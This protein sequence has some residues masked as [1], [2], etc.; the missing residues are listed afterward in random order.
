MLIKKWLNLLL[1]SSTFNSYNM[2]NIVLVSEHG[3]PSI[4]YLMKYLKQGNILTKEGSSLIETDWNGKPLEKWTADHIVKNSVIIRWGNQIPVHMDKCIVYNRA[5]AIMKASDKRGARQILRD[6]GVNIPKF[7]TKKNFSEEDL[8]IIGRPRRHSKGIGMIILRTKEDFLKHYE[9]NYEKGWYYS[10][11]IDKEHEYR[12]HCA[13]GKILAI[14]EKP[15]PKNKSTVNWG[16][17]VIDQDDWRVLLWKEYNYEWCKQALLAV[18]SLGLDFGAVDMIT[19]GKDCY[20]LEVNTAGCLTESKYLKQKYIDYFKWLFR[21]NSRR[22]HFDFSKYKEP[23]S[24]SW[25]EKQLIS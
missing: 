12:F 3:A 24:F 10:K 25:K 18:K 16:Y 15:R 8:P 4:K 14:Q 19:K 2:E 7:I 5:S 17:A 22:E 6:A 21:N 9:E 1:R 11:L 20:V 23:V 13:H